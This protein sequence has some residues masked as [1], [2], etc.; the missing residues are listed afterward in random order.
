MS[1]HLPDLRERQLVLW[2]GIGSEAFRRGGNYDAKAQH[3]TICR[4]V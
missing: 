3:A 1:I 4:L 2:A